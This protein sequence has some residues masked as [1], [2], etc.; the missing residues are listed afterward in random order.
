MLPWGL[1]SDHGSAALRRL[2][3]D[4]C[5]TD[6][7]VG[8]DNSGGIFPI[9]RGV[10]FLLLSSSPGSATRQTRC[11][12]GE[13]DPAVLETARR[14]DA[15][16]NAADD[17]DR[18]VDTGPA[19]PPVGA[20]AGDS[21]RARAARTCASSSASLRASPALSDARGLGRDVRARAEQDR[22]PRA[23]LADAGAGLPVVEGK[24]VD[25]FDVRLEDCALRVPARASA[26]ASPS[27]D[28]P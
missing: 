1:A 24:H 28:A 9:H 23:V 7:I 25:P 21:A 10:R 27:F 14:A 18:H 6:T 3:F 2:L 12:L 22:R 26:P 20:G 11:R 13:R 4:R 19:A 16:A 17:R 5:S 15:R 8:F